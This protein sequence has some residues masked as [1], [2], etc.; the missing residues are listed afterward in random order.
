[1]QTVLNYV[2]FFFIYAFLGWCTEVIF[3]ACVRGVFENRGFFNGPIC[4]IYGFGVVIVVFFLEPLKENFWILFLGSVVLTSVLEL[5]TGYLMEKIFKHRWWDYSRMPLNIGGYV[6][7]AFSL[8]WGFACVFLVDII[9]P[10][11]AFFVNHIPNLVTYIALPIFVAT[12]FTDLIA[13]STSV[14]HF[15]KKLEDIEKMAAQIHQVSDEIGRKLSDKAIEV[16]EKESTKKIVE[17]VMESRVDA[18]TKLE[19]LKIS[20]DE[21]EREL[22]VIQRRLI[23]A[24]PTMRST[25]HAEAFAK[26]K[27]KM[28]CTK[29]RTRHHN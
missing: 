4:P 11:I 22:S 18:Q 28:A 17:S 23:K 25:K 2:W 29:H 21:K 14:F 24:F 27:E 20:L 8:I 9:H 7:L 1:M 16:K 13:T 5:I 12:F 6:C 10:S 3:A 19:T 15:N 26:I